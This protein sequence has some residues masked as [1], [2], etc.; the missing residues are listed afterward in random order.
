MDNIPLR[1][2]RRLAPPLPLAILW[3][4]LEVG[5]PEAAAVPQAAQVIH[6]RLASYTRQQVAQGGLLLA[7]LGYENKTVLKALAGRLRELS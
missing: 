3:A 2:Y 6:R 4:C 1:E 7:H 5:Q